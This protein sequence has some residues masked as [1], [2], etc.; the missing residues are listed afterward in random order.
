MAD[1]LLIMLSKSGY[2]TSLCGFNI[3]AIFNSYDIPKQGGNYF[4]VGRARKIS[5]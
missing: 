4:H 3:S 1:E 2:S 5:W